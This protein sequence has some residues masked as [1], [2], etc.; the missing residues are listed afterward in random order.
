MS[1]AA[2]AA[3][4]AIINPPTLRP[5]SEFDRQRAMSH[6][7]KN[8]SPRAN[9]RTRETTMAA[10]RQRAGEREIRRQDVQSALVTSYEG[11]A[12]VQGDDPDQWRPAQPW[13]IF[14]V[15]RLNRVSHQDWLR[16]GYETLCVGPFRYGDVLF[17]ATMARD[18]TTLL[19]NLDTGRARQYITL[20]PHDGAPLLD[21]RRTRH[22]SDFAQ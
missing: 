17:G 15:Q 22:C 18:G 6:A 19:V 4:A 7:K 14:A 20:P 2:A 8:V 13:Q 1:A 16:R 9:S 12:F 21:L 3:A 11:R 5:L 10:A